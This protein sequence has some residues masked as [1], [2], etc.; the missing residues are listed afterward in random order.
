MGILMR[1]IDYADPNSLG[2][3]LRARRLVHVSDLI[4]SIFER[5][6]KVDILDIGGR[7]QY[8]RLFDDDYLESRNARIVLLNLDAAQLEDRDDPRFSSEQ[9]DACDLVRFSDNAFDLVHSNATIEHVGDW[10]RIE[11]FAKEVRR[12]A[13][14]YYVQTPYFWF[15]IEPHIL[16]PFFH[17][18]PD[19]VQAKILLANF[20]P[21]SA[22]ANFAPDAAKAPDIG[23]A[24]RGVHGVRLL[25]R[26][27]M[28]FLFSDGDLRMEW[29][30]PLPKSLIAIRRA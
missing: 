13:P 18:L 22:I 9:G 14:S 4:D 26:A 17:W 21:R 10:R 12:L 16:L 29:L 15:P 25:D 1:A 11:A 7:R 5:E 24:M 27:Q 19:G 23:S 28:R 8:W 20:A 30:G 6:G 2:S 3:R